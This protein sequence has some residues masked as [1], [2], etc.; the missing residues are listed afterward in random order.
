MDF[1]WRAVLHVLFTYPE[2]A[3]YSNLV[4]TPYTN[5]S[6]EIRKRHHAVMLKTSPQTSDNIYI[7]SCRKAITTSLAMHIEAELHNYR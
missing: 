2:G 5:A 3:H 7:W 6:S 4:C 1:S